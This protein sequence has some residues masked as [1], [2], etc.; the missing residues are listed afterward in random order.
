MISVLIPSRG[1]P[2]L[3]ERFLRSVASCCER[4]VEV[5]VRLDSD[6]CDNYRSQ[7]AMGIPERVRVH[8]IVGDPGVGMG[9]MTNECM[10]EANGDII[11]L[12]G[13]DLVVRTMGF[14]RLVADAMPSDGIGLVF[15]DDKFQGMN[16][17][18]HP[19][20]GRTVINSWGGK[21]V[22]D[23]YK[24]EFID[25]HIMDVFRR[26]GR[27]GHRRINY[28]PDLVTEHMHHLNGKAQMDD[29]YQK[30]MEF[31]VSAHVYEF[32]ATKRQQDAEAMQRKV[33][34]A[35]A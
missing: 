17:A 33:E 12:A 35:Q 15:G 34:E 27:L 7:R 1:R 10:D 23:E 26:L 25:T 3:L 2:A 20:L 30:P 8:F 19:F 4:P 28:V 11:M 16:L 22:P 6:D 14:D 32:F 18:T 31:S 9:R 24:A 21:V 13:D 5:I 29:T